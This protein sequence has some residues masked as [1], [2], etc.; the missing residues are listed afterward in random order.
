MLRRLVILFSVFLFSC[1][2]VGPLYLPPPP[3]EP[4]YATLIFMRAPGMAGAAWPHHFYVDQKL[5]AKLYVQCYTYVAVKEGTHE[6]HSGIS[7]EFRGLLHTVEM[8]AGETYYYQESRSVNGILPSGTFITIEHID[9]SRMLRRATAET[10]IKTYNL[11]K[12]IL[13]RVD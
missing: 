6:V 13:A 12:P 3:A 8:H 2:S 7:P 5:V 4:G 11:Q 9:T 10:E 1:A